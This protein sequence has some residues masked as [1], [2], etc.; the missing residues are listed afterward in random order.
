MVTK[1]ENE[2]TYKLGPKR[3]SPKESKDSE[4]E[5][6]RAE[7]DVEGSQRKPSDTLIEQMSNADT[8][9]TDGTD[10]ERGTGGDDVN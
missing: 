6:E 1:N 7:S 8:P 2:Y 3:S 10:I 9:L 5:A 4:L